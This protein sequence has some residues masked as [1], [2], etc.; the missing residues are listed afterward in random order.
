VAVSPKR[1]S[2]ALDEELVIAMRN[3][4]AEQDSKKAMKVLE[5]ISRIIR[6]PRTCDCGQSHDHC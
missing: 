4:I 2:I 1:V 5:T 6:T 3:A